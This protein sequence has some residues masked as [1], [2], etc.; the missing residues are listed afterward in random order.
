MTGMNIVTWQEIS[1]SEFIYK[2]KMNLFCVKGQRFRSYPLETDILFI[3]I[4]FPGSLGG[5]EPPTVQET[6]VHF[7]GG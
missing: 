1:K 4:G 2:E 5:K 7:L 6:Q 3:L